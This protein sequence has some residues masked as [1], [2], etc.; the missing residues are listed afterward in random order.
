MKPCT[1]GHWALIQRASKENDRVLLFVSTADRGGTQGEALVRGSDMSEVWQRFLSIHLPGNVGLELVRTPIRRIYETLGEADK[2]G[3]V[4]SFA[5]YS[6]PDDIASRFGLDRQKKYFG[7]LQKHGQVRFVAVERLGDQDVSATQMR[8]LFEEG[9]RDAFISLLPTPVDG[10]AIWEYLQ[11][12]R[13]VREG[14][15]EG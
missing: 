12:R 15:D 1:R 8:K 10:P 5:V 3:S 7:D 4:D 14:G 2:T 13:F 11:L 6:D 9:M